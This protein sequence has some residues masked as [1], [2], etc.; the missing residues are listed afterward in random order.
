MNMTDIH[1]LLRDKGRLF[2]DELGIVAATQPFRWLIAAI[3][4]GRRINETIA[5]RTY[6]ALAR[7]R[8]LTPYA[9][10]RAGRDVLIAAMGEGEYVRYDNM[11]SD[12]LIGLSERLIDLY[13]GNVEAVHARAATPADLEAALL[14]FRG[15]GPVTL[16]IFLRELRGV[17]TKADPPLTE[18]ELLAARRLG[19]TRSRR[20]RHALVELKELWRTHAVSG[21]DFR[22]LETALVRTGL[23]LRRRQRAR[24]LREQKAIARF[25][26]C[27]PRLTRPASPAR[28]TRRRCVRRAGRAR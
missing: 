7:R 26:R 5:K 16:S 19:L 23:E 27:A 15:I 1:A 28:A 9:I 10:V 13:G 25:T 2:S 21:Y 8:L 6:F 20:P 14:A 4:F 12:Y 18:I 11:T 17:W 22:H 3:L 24:S